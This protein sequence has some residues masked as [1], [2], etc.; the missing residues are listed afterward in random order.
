MFFMK[1]LSHTIHLHPSYFGPKIQEVILQKLYADVEG[2]TNGR[3]GYVV[4]VNSIDNLT[5]LQAGSR[6]LY[7]SGDAEFTLQYSAIVMKPFKGEVV[8]A[9]VDK[10][11]K[12][13]PDDLR[14]QPESNP[15]SFVSDQAGESIKRG[16]K[17]RI[18][19]MGIR[20]DQ[21]ELFA[22]GSIKGDFLGLL[23]Q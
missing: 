16:A 7:G 10:V 15:P 22:I 5:D 2:T 12:Y 13:I 11:G 1:K 9:I 20:T 8:D 18:R 14:F 23:D 6:V 3:Y 21:T 17:V 19:L 4:A